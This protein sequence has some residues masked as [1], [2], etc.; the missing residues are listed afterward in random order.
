MRDELAERMRR[1]QR[2][3]LLQGYP[4]RPLMLAATH[5]PAPTRDPRRPLLVGV[6]PHPFCN[7]RVKGCGFCTFPHER[8]TNAGA[9]DVTDAVSAEVRRHAARGVEPVEGLYLGGGTANLT[10]PDAFAA[11]CDA[12]RES[13]DLSVAEV[14]FEGVPKYFLTKD[15]RLLHTLVERLP[16]RH[17]RVSLGVQTFDPAWLERMGRKGFGDASTVERV[18]ERAHGLGMTTSVDLLMNLPGQHVRET[19]ADLERADA[20][21]V[22]QI[23]LYHLVLYA[24][25]GT[26]WSRDEKLVSLR[27]S[28]SAACE[29]WLEARA[30]LLSRGFVQT[31]LTNF[32]RREVH[33]SSK[34]FVYELASFA[35][36]QRD[37]LG[38]GPGAISTVQRAPLRAGEAEAPHKWIN[39]SDAADYAAA[40]RDGSGHVGRE[41]SYRHPE[42]RALLYVTRGLSRG[43]VDLDV[44]RGA[45]GRHGHDVLDACEREGLLTRD[46]SVVRLTPRGMFYADS[47]TGLLAS[48]RAEQI[49]RRVRG[50]VNDARPEMMG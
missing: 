26:P 29:A 31:T 44:T 45:L 1:D 37:A 28:T 25:L 15:A 4:M 32:E 2:H 41:F 16:A 14:S 12:L 50:A 36:W 39:L 5:D 34:R 20:M 40:V 27:K 19:L 18:I 23:C 21:G 7:P 47:V 11:L 49:G 10:P 22:D 35:P 13:F 24:G 30:W 3:R 46:G 48:R 38:F 42:D 8:F 17:H 6:L 43:W 9:R 33:E